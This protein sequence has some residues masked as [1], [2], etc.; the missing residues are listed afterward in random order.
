[1]LLAL[2]P[3]SIRSNST[4]VYISYLLDCSSCPYT[5]RLRN[6]PPLLGEVEKPLDIYTFY[7]LTRFRRTL[8]FLNPRSTTYTLGPLILLI[9][10]LLLVLAS[11]L[12]L[13]YYVL[14]RREQDSLSFVFV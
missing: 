14:R 1:M 13:N 5:L 8:R 7:I 3:Y 9:L 11:S 2:D 6:R 4:P 12:N 10:L